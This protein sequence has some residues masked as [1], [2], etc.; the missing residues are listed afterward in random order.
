MINNSLNLVVGY[1]LA[2]VLYGGYTAHLLIRR[3][4]LATALAPHSDIAH[5]DS[6]DS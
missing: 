6:K 5:P 4:A 3:R 2:A 1:G